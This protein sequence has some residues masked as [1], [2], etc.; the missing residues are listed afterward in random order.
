VVPPPEPEPI[1][2]AAPFLA[3]LHATRAKTQAEPLPVPASILQPG[4]VL[5]RNAFSA[6]EQQSLVDTCIRVGEHAKAGFFTPT[7][8]AN[9]AIGS[10]SMRL[11]MVCLGRHWDHCNG[12]YSPRRTN[13]DDEPVLPV[14]D[15]LS[16]AAAK[17]ARARSAKERAWP[18]PALKIPE[19]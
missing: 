11:Q 1:H 17:V 14:P 12:S 10:H 9:G 8:E 6:H 15:E 5:L 18:D 3:K 2:P 4:C 19:T 16:A 13:I 7:Y